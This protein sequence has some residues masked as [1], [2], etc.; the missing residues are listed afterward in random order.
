MRSKPAGLDNLR[1]HHSKPV[2]AWAAQNK[3]DI[4]LFYLPN[5]RPGLNLE[6]RLNA[7]SKHAIGSKVPVRAKAKLRAEATEHMTHT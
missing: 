5:Y 6:K 4:E 1:V 7:D 3:L 2:K